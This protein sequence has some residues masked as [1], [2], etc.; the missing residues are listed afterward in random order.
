[1]G[2]IESEEVNVKT[3]KVYK[4]PSL[5]TEA[6]KVGFSWPAA[7]FIVF[8]ML[9]KKLWTMAGL[10]ILAYIVLTIVQDTALKSGGAGVILIVLIAHLALALIPA[11]KGNEWRVKNLTKRGFKFVDSVSA[12]T[13]EAA[14]AQILISPG[15]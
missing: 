10:W 12:E 13:P 11:F 14:I 15:V 9:A 3:Y 8:W 4:H 7:F 6:V 1:V 5:G 2:S